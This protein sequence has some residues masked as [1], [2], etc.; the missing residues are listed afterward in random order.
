MSG[1]FGWI[2]SHLI[3]VLCLLA[4]LVLF[5]A[6]FIG[7]RMWNSRIRTD[8]QTKAEND[9]KSLDVRVNYVIDPIMP[10]DPKIEYASA[11]NA[12][13]TKWFKEHRDRQSKELQS[14]LGAAESLNKEGHD[15]LMP[16]IFPDPP[17][18][19][20]ATKVIEFTRL[21]AGDPT[22]N[23]PSVYQ[24][25]LKALNA[26][27]PPDP[28]AVNEQVTDLRMKEVD[29]LKNASGQAILTPEQNDQILQALIDYR[30]GVYQGR[31][32]QISV[33]AGKEIFFTFPEANLASRAIR[34][35][36]SVQLTEVDDGAGIDDC[37]QWQWD[38]WV[39]RDILLAVAKANRASDNKLTPVEQSVVK[40]IERVNVRELPLR[41]EFRLDRT[42]GEP[43]V[44][45]Q[46]PIDLRK[47][48]TG[49]ASTKANQQ[50]DVR[51]A[52]LVVVASSARLPQLL[53]AISKTNLMTVLNVTLEPVDA[54]ADLQAGFFYGTEHVV[55]AT[56]QIETLWLRSWTKP[57]MPRMVAA[58]LAVVM[59]EP[60]EGE[61][62]VPGAEAAPEPAP[63]TPASE[64]GDGGE[65]PNRRNVPDDP[66]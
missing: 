45:G 48:I 1:L 47:S 17:K 44:N 30:L 6:G 64:T 26:G 21:I 7:S 57:L 33:Y 11:P 2:K 61:A 36:W 32:S 59:P 46:V 58:L 53:E 50:Y 40:R 39:F 35:P 20:L 28:K 65:R 51:N 31:A 60:K 37:F 66:R 13:V 22:A 14:L 29:K 56:I 54:I 43:A 38:Y 4:I 42:E 10:G 41:N 19:E 24:E 23:I 49:R 52:E 62:A 3:V 55:R 12:A 18:E 34:L 15:V 63:E 5:P 9:S 25:L 16:G 27:A 8:R